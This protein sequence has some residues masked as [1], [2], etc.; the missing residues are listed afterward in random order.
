[1]KQMA[2]ESLGLQKKTVEMLEELV[3]NR[4]KDKEQRKEMDSDLKNHRNKMVSLLENMLKSGG[5]RKRN[6]YSFDD[7]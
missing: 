4:E 5:K 6:S 1:M 3:K 7:E 2:E